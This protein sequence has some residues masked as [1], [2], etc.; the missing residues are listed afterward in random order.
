MGQ[1]SN[2]HYIKCYI[3]PSILEPLLSIDQTFVFGVNR[4]VGMPDFNLW[5]FKGQLIHRQQAI[6]S[7]VNGHINII[8]IISINVDNRELP[9]SLH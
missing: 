9:N 8:A 2:M 5:S 7:Q 4:K 1:R 6:G 3:S